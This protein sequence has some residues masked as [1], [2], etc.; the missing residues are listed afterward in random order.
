MS[1]RSRLLVVCAALLGA[2]G[3]LTGAATLT[4]YTADIPAAGRAPV[5][6]AVTG[7]E[8]VAGLT[9][10]ALL[11]VAGVAAAV[12]LAG[13]AR[14][15]L[16]VVLALA[17]AWLGVLLATATRPAPADVAAL[18]TAPAGAGLPA[19]VEATAAPLVAVVGVLLLLVAG[20][21]LAVAEPRLPRFGARYAAAQ[22]RRAE[23]DPDR[24]AWDAL[25]A[26]RDPT[27]G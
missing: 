26:G 17:G 25:D 7:A 1:A 23:P 15:V 14:R 5:R 22:D 9:A 8:A 13:P 20:A 21:A 3:A 19:S 10:V 2:A 16:G 11:A 12:A 4:W 6:V 27:L 18:P 24:A